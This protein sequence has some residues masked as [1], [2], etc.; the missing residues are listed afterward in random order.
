MIDTPRRLLKFSEFL[1][2]TRNADDRQQSK[3]KERS[4][5]VSEAAI[6]STNLSDPLPVILTFRR[7][8]VL[9]LFDGRV[10]ATYVEGRTKAEIVFPSVL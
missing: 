8:Q 2:S 9:R 6:A 7:T 4:Q 10:I 1:A 5:T 3:V